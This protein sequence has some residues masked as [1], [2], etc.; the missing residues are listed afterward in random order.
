MIDVDGSP[1]GYIAW[2]NHYTMTSGIRMLR[3]VVKNDKFGVQRMEMLAIYFAIADNCIHFRKIKNSMKNK[4]KRHQKKEQQQ[5][6]TIEIRSDSKSTIEQLQGLSQIR[7]MILQRIFKTIRKFL[8]GLTT[9]SSCII[10]FNYLERTRNL[11]GLMLEQLRRK[12]K[13]Q[14]FIL[15]SQENIMARY[16]RRYL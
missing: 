5:K 3:P 11:A 7:D 6:I 13:E 8:K 4:N 1:S 10:L 2:Y 15:L 14:Q 9:T 16:R 12:K